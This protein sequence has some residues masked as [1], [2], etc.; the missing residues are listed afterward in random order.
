M[1]YPH[2]PCI[3]VLRGH[4]GK[5]IAVNTVNGL[6]KLLRRTAKTLCDHAHDLAFFRR[7]DLV[8]VT[9]DQPPQVVDL[10]GG[11]LQFLPNVLKCKQRIIIAD[12]LLQRI[13]CLGLFHQ[14][15]QFLDQCLYVFSLEPVGS[16]QK[17]QVRIGFAPVIVNHR[18][19]GR[20]RLSRKGCLG[21]IGTEKLTGSLEGR[22]H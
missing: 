1:R 15:P 11:L 12:I 20:F 3:Q 10:Q 16:G 2:E 17:R 21:L 5:V 18:K 6:D 19:R 7:K 13:H 9:N 14:P 22:P 8:I 4:S